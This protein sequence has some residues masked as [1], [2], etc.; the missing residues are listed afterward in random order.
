MSED[1]EISID[2]DDIRPDSKVDDT[3]LVN[4][5]LKSIDVQLSDE[6]K[7]KIE[8]NRKNRPS[9][10]TVE[11]PQGPAGELTA[12]EM[13]QC[14]ELY[15]DLSSFLSEKENI[16]SGSG[17]M[18]TIPTGFDLL[19]TITAGGIPSGALTVVAGNPATFKSALAGQIIG[20]A[21]KVMKGKLFAN[22]LDTESA[23]TMQRLY[24]MGV[25]YPPIRPIEDISVEKVFKTLQCIIAYKELKNLVSVPSIVVWDSVANTSTEVEMKTPDLDINKVIGLRARILS[26]VLPRFVSK[27]REYNISVIA[28]NQLR[29]KIDMGQYSSAPDL[30]WMGDKSMP[31]GNAL[32]FNAFLLMM[33][34]NGGDLDPTKYGFTGVKVVLKCIKNKLFAP[35]IPITLIVNF[36]TGISNF[37]SNHEFLVDNKIIK[38]ASWY[39][40][41]GYDKKYRVR[42][43]EELYMTDST[44]KELFD[45]L[46]QTGLKSILLDPNRPDFEMAS[47][48]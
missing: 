10:S 41:P 8:D 31:G 38:A 29:D 20:N 14:K 39:T 17:I 22:Y 46:V 1:I 33:L 16:K 24:S 34:K 15:A 35:N 32:K 21:Q 40:L 23:T 30:K 37:W 42:E 2:N 4:D 7:K 13:Q 36:N 18:K 5:A 25:R 3:K 27:M 9:V 28:I 44:F 26:F 47:D 6:E 19:D 12:Q 43:A 45:E 48:E 11:I